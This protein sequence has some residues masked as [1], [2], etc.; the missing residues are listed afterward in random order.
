MASSQSFWAAYHL[1]AVIGLDSFENTERAF[2]KGKT[3]QNSKNVGYNNDRIRM[4][5][6]PRRCSIET[7]A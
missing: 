4:L 3:G 6:S 7:G 2:T 5:K 1:P